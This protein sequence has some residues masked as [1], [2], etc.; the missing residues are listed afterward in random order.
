MSR[1]SV[2]GITDLPCYECYVDSQ[3]DAFLRIRST[4]KNHTVCN[5]KE[6]KLELGLIRCW[7]TYKEINRVVEAA[8]NSLSQTEYCL[9][10]TLHHFILWK[11][12]GLNTDMIIF[13]FTKLFAPQ[14]LEKQNVLRTCKAPQR[15]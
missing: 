1:S 5:W 2:N 7:H 15:S 11:M 14:Y 3:N 12:M 10:P 8:G 9:P 4:P 6:P 13:G